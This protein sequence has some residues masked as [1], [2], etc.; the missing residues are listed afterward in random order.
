MEEEILSKTTIK[1]YHQCLVLFIYLFIYFNPGIQV[2]NFDSLNFTYCNNLS[3]K[4]WLSPYKW[5]TRTHKLSLTDSNK[6]YLF[7]ILVQ[8][9]YSCDCVYLSATVYG[10]LRDESNEFENTMKV[11][12][13]WFTRG[14]ALLMHFFILSRRESISNYFN[15]FFQFHKQFLS[16][17]QHKF[18]TLLYF[19]VG[20]G[21]RSES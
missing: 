1:Y 17:L 12:L 9:Y 21:M 8:F 16:N 18:Y 14:A 20:I 11:S 10:M 5:N 19:Y 7:C 2:I 15:Q 3:N 4:F 6:H 13:H